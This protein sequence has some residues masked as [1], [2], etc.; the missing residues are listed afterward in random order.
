MDRI[1]PGL[2]WMYGQ[3]ESHGAINTQWITLKYDTRRFFK[4]YKYYLSIN[5]KYWRTISKKVHKGVISVVNPDKKYISLPPLPKIIKYRFRN[6]NFSSF[7]EKIPVLHCFKS[8]LAL[9]AWMIQIEFFQ[10]N[11]FPKRFSSIL[12]H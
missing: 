10:D 11:C 9:T 8:Y 7:W 2:F 5:I 6:I 3:C 12:Y 1:A 4:R